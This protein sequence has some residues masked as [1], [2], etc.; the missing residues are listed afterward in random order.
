[1]AIFL[2]TTINGD[3]SIFSDGCVNQMNTS[4]HSIVQKTYVTNKSTDYLLEQVKLVNTDHKYSQ[5]IT[6]N[7]TL[8]YRKWESGLLTYEGWS[9]SETNGICQSVVDGMISGSYATQELV[10]WDVYPIPF[11]SAPYF[12]FIVVGANDSI[13]IGDYIPQVLWYGTFGATTDLYKYP[14]RCKLIRG[15]TK[16]YGNPQL[17]WQASGYWK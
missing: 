10:V 5:S 1:V 2:D 4:D 6:V 13:Y 16:V 9:R 11:I 8:Y 14:N 15:S 17:Q 7:S 12:S 3:I